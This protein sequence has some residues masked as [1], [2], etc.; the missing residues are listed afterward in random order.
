MF[1]K[2]SKQFVIYG[3]GG[4]L[5]RF[6]SVFTAPIYTRFLSTEEY[7]RLDLA[8][9]IFAILVI[10]TSMEMNSGYARSYYEV[11]STNLLRELRGTVYIFYFISNV[12]LL[13][14]FFGFFNYLNQLI[15]L[16]DMRLLIPVVLNLLPM[17]F[18]ALAL[19]TFRFE[20]KPV[21]HTKIAVSNGVLTALGGIFAVTVLKSGVIGILWANTLV[22][23][24][25]C[26]LISIFLFKYVWFSP[27]LKFLKETFAYSAPIT[28]S[29]IGSWIR[30]Y[31]GRIF[32]AG[33]LSMSML[34]VYSLA[35]KVSL[36]SKLAN[37]AFRLTWQPK[38]IALFDE[39]NSEKKI[40]S[41]LNYYMIFLFFIV[42]GIVSFS[43]F[44]IK[45]LAP[46]SYIKAI[47]VVGLIV[48]STMWEGSTNILGLGNNWERKTYYNTFGNIC[49]AAITLII[50]YFGISKGGIFIAAVALLIGSLI[51]AIL[52]LITSQYNH[53]IPY[54]YFKIGIVMLFS[55]IYGTISYIIFSILH[56]KG[57]EFVIIMLTIGI[58][59]LFA[60]YLILLNKYEKEK[61]VLWI[62]SFRFKKVN[63]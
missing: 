55:S 62:K 63:K 15:T 38:A 56:Y 20:Q 46:A 44:I 61:T 30:Q 29:R 10:L 57:F 48:V 27:S 45:A 13:T 16:I 52:I 43:P 3:L 28:P 40:A 21:I 8:T 60:M 51:R 47:S 58:L 5:T 26:L 23:Y 6:V 37:N 9:T 42:V 18:I 41:V 24:F 11:K 31:I 59:M 7:G 25:I 1:K 12:I 33:A 22:S 39:K 36:I 4:F 50:L 19:V 17:H 49:A 35:L 53:R 34:G 14:L 2:Y 54:S 32:I